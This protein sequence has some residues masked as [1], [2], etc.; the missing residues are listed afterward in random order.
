MAS[1]HS[2][3]TNY[4]KLNPIKSHS[5]HHEITI[6]LWFFQFV[7]LI[8][9]GLNI[10]FPMVFLW[11]SC[12]FPI[13]FPFSYGFPMVFPMVFPLSY[14][15]SMFFPCFSTAPQPA[16]HAV[17]PPRHRQAP[18]DAG[19][20]EGGA[21]AAPREGQG[22]AVVGRRRGNGCRGPRRRS[23]GWFM[24]GWWCTIIESIQNTL[25]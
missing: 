15:F 7:K 17:F 10:H 13:M 3:V 20:H 2:Y 4:Q 19:V 8:H 23:P 25:W 18:Q 21:H 22:Q 16:L 14:G 5:N 9:P 1:F 12:G 6:F 24:T 11:F